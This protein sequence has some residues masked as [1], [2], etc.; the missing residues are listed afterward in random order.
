MTDH[1]RLLLEGLD[2]L[3][4]MAKITK[5]TRAAFIRTQD[6]EHAHAL[7]EELAAEIGCP[8]HHVTP[9]G[10]RRFERAHATWS[11]VNENQLTPVEMLQTAAGLGGLVVF[12]EFVSQIQDGNQNVQARVLFAELL[13]RENLGSNGLVL[14]L[15][16]APPAEAHIPALSAGQVVR[17]SIGYPRAGELTRL[18]RAE[19]ARFS[20]LAGK[21]VEIEKIR[22]AAPKLADCLVGLTRKAARDLLSDG[23]ASD[24]IDLG[25]AEDFLSAKK[26]DRLNQELAMEVL[27]TSKVETPIGVD[28]LL[29]RIAILRSK[30]RIHGPER[31]RGILI[32]GPPGTGK[33]MLARAAGELTGLPVVVFK[34]SALMNSLLGETERLFAR[35]FA[36]LEAMAPAIVFIDEIEKAFGDS[37]ERDGGTM[38]RVS[39]ALLSWLSDNM[40]PN[41]II[42]TCNNPHRFGDIGAAMTRSGRFDE[43]FFLDVPDAHARELI[44]RRSLPQTLGRDQTLVAELAGA[45]QLFSGADIVS[46][47]RL[48][49]AYADYKGEPL[50]RVHLINEM[51]RKQARAAA[52]YEQF[53]PIRKWG[54]DHCEPAA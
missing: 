33:T 21:P 45:S 14:A 31:A 19:V 42:A 36:T 44:L 35:A 13:A 8:L 32:V 6:R 22:A 53:E 47:I 38:M 20:H 7:I 3:C 46:A 18:V 17:Y 48:A 1:T 2:R 49:Q 23:L 27:D 16:E 39:G 34:I 9:S 50:S 25:A 43:S 30:M 10:V 29:E 5:S 24:E 40:S 15:V 52:L 28:R 11:V 26:I 51:Q 12:E 41:F 37:G 54:A 4:R